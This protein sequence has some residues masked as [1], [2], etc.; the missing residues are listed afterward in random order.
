[1]T[2]VDGIRCG[3]GAPLQTLV[4]AV[5]ALVLAF[6]L[7]GCGLVPGPGDEV[8]CTAIGCDSQVVFELAEIELASDRSYE[9]EACLD[10]LCEAATVQPPPRGATIVGQRGGLTISADENFVA[11]V[12]PKGDYSGA[13]AASLR[14]QPGD[15]DAF[16]I[17]VEVELERTQPNGP[18]CPP[19]CW[20]AIVRA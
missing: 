19:V 10:D 16:E 9:I 5:T 1:V 11:L 14:I 8:V 12:L 3:R 6:G 4:A 18:N 20:Q 2:C 15:G 7:V 17:E 13:R